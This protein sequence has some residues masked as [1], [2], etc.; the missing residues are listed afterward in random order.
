MTRN[1]STLIIGL[2]LILAGLGVKSAQAP[3]APAGMQNPLPQAVP[4]ATGTIKAEANLVLVDAI[5]TDKKGNYIQDMKQEEFH[6]FEDDVEQKTSSFS[7]GT[8]IQ[9][10]TPQA[11]RYMVLFFDNSTMDTQDQMRARQAAAKFVERTASPN[12]LMAV[13]DFVG[14]LNVAQNFTA[15][16]ERLQRAV[17]GVKYSAV[18]PSPPAAGVQ[19][20]SLGAPPM[21]SVASNDFAARSVLLA[22]R[23]VAKMLQTVPGRKT[24]VLFSSGFPLTADR[25]SEL[26]A[27]TDALNK[28]NI[29]VYPVDV[30]GLL[31]MASPTGGLRLPALPGLAPQEG[32]DSSFPHLAGL[33]ASLVMLPDPQRPGGGGGG[34]GGGPSGGGAG[35]SGVGSGG[36]R[37]GT[38][39]GGTSGGGAGGARGGAGGTTGGAKGGAGTTTGG[40]G[41]GKGGAGTTGG[42]GGGGGNTGRPMSNYNPNATTNLAVICSS[43]MANQ[44]PRCATLQT[45]NNIPPSVATNQQI[46]YA[47]A[48]ATGGFPIFNTNDF[49]AA[50]DKIAKEM[51]ESYIL[52]Y[53]PPGHIHDGR[54][55][56][57]R[58]KVDRGGTIVRARS[59]YFDVKS[60]DLLAGRPE[61]K[62]L[63]AQAAS[64]ERGDIPVTMSAPY[65]YV[66]PDVARVNLAASFPASAIDF[67]KQK[68]NFHS[69]INVLG[70]AYR[71]DGSV[72]ARFSDSLKLDYDKKE[73]KEAS[74]G[75][76]PYQTVFNI[77]P[78]KYTLKLVLS[79]GGQ[80]FGKYEMPLTVDPFSGNEFA[81]AGPA[82]SSE[83][84][85]V[86]QLSVSMDEAL[87]EERT[88]LLFKGMQIVPS[89]N[90]RF[91]KDDSPVFYVELYD[92]VLKR[93][94]PRLGVLFDI[95]N[96]KT[97]QQVYSSNT[98]PVNDYVQ[99]GSPLVPVGLKLPVDE[100]Q[101]GDYRIEIRGRDSAGNASPV[102]SAD[103]SIE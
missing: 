92:P 15:D 79:A 96:R 69:Q 103:F 97:N 75:T 71:P 66:G 91:G 12:R 38:G 62:T 28:A 9:P 67:E 54:Y 45:L 44:D 89:S 13:V 86:S 43:I 50:L 35:G 61:E 83:M 36:G 81:L 25:Q 47:L 49:L 14:T 102:R 16:G 85:P 27:T 21:L 48:S 77:A 58:V 73:F 31:A 29:A 52:G 82:L 51:N 22:M 55:H 63:E 2:F 64:P 4:T 98:V 26:T 20:A 8:D 60:R 39:G 18:Q 7:H 80:K 90:N 74:K 101:A 95:V 42:R 19:V 94:I 17:S 10:D 84:V 72:A 34:A 76:L 30:R 33:V 57:I 65:F 53:T 100:L 59:G 40:T 88:P 11:Q 87:L 37:G 56:R 41:A 93:D 46:L 78:G 99:K 1:H 32:A 3:A 5:V 70:I 24:L 6:V 23:A 68:S